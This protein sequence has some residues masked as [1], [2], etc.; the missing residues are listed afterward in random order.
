MSVTAWPFITHD[1]AGV[2][3]VEG[4]RTKVIELALD[5][6]AYGWDAEQIQ[7]QHPD[8][9]LPQ[10]HAALGYYF[11]HQ[12]ECDRQLDEGRRQADEICARFE[13]PALLAK[14]R[15]AAGT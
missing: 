14:L 12:E 4:T 2:A 1:A 5:H 13:N 8:L 10:I 7:R 6:R 11:D 9:S 15:S 3:L